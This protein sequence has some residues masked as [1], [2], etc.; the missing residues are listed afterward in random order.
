MT[1]YIIP[2]VTLAEA[3]AITRDIFGD[4]AATEDLIKRILL[5]LTEDREH[6]ASL[7]DPWVEAPQGAVIPEGVL[8]R[9]EYSDG[10]ASEY[11]SDKGGESATLG[12]MLVRQSDLPKVV[13]PKS[14]RDRLIDEVIKESERPQSPLTDKWIRGTVGEWIDRVESAVKVV[15]GDDE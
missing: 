8:Y 5:I 4:H 7:Q 2:E 3:D 12:T 13:P 14:R 10:S 6:V 9:V 11:V 1:D 15:D